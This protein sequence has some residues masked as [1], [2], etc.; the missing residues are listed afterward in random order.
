MQISTELFG[1]LI[2]GFIALVGLAAW[3]GALSQK[4]KNQDKTIETNKISIAQFREDNKQEHRDIMN[5]IK[6]INQYLRD[7]YHNG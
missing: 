2:T 3:V 1:G 7:G 4:V 6:S 5:E